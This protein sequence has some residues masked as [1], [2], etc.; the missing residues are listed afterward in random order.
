MMQTPV[1]IPSEA[2]VMIL[3]GAVLLPNG[4]LPLRIFE[5]R[6]RAM[7]EWAL[8]HD[9]MF[10]IALMKPGISESVTEDQFF[11]TAGIGLISAS[12]T[13]SDG[14]SN[15]M[16]HGL[17][18]VRF[19]GFPQLKPFRI[20]QI[21][22]VPSVTGDAAEAD[23]LVHDLR[24]QCSIIRVNGSPL[25]DSFQEMLGKITD[26]AVLADTV[27]HSLIGNASDRQGLIEEADATARLRTILRLLREQFPAS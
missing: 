12:V 14:T 3:P 13:Q 18:R 16:L 17:T 26:P 24:E 6:Y 25:P 4:I 10:C 11:H 1:A 15:L 2:P 9:R 21:E 5:P 8:E 7:L 27:A 22:E 19:V 23:A 20:A